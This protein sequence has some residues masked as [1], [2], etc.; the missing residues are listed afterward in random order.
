M[1]RI[2]TIIQSSILPIARTSLIHAL[3]SFVV[4]RARNAIILRYISSYVFANARSTASAD[5]EHRQVFDAPMSCHRM[6]WPHR[7][8]FISCIS[9]NCNHNINGAVIRRGK[10]I[11]AFRACKTCINAFSTQDSNRCRIRLA[12]RFDPADTLI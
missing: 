6:T 7:T 3:W 11:P 2:R 10:F 1:V 12:C 4:S 8:G 9:A 5:C